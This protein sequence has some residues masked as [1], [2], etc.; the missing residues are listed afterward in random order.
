MWITYLYCLV[1]HASEIVLQGPYLALVDKAVIN[2]H[3]AVK[4]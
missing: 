4:Y 2:P 3:E 1:T